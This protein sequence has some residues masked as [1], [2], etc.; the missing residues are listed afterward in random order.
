M[1]RTI[2]LI[3]AVMTVFLSHGA[4]FSYRFDS[5][6]LP[7]ALQLILS[8][9]P[10]L[11]LNFIY[12]EL[13]NYKTSAHVQADTAYDALRQTIG[14]NPVT[15]ANARGTYYLEALQHGRHIFTGRVTDAEGPLPGATLLL[16]TPKDSTVITYGITDDAGRFFIP[17]DKKKVIIKA[18]CMGYVTAY[19]ECD[20]FDAGDIVLVAKPIALNAVNIEARGTTLEA[21]KNIYIPSQRQ[22]QFSQTGIDLLR[23]MG[24]PS[25]VVE[26]GS[27][28]VTDVFGN[29]C[30]L[31]I[32]YLPASPEDMQTI[33]ITDVKRIEVLDSPA[34]PRFR[35]ATKAINIIVQKY[36]YGGYTK[37]RASETTL[38]GYKNSASIF[39]KFTYKKMTYDLYAGANNRVDHHSAM[40]MTS[41]YT[42]ADGVVTRHERTTKSKYIENSYPVT[43]RAVFDTKRLQVSNLVSYTHEAEPDKNR[44]GTISYNTRPNLNY[45]YSRTDNNRANSV[46]YDGSLFWVHP[47]DFAI[48]Y[49]HSASYTHRDNSSAFV[50]SAL[51]Y[52][53]DNK[54]A[55][56]KTVLRCD[57]SVLKAFGP[58]HRIKIGTG[59]LHLH[60]KVHYTN[61]TYFTDDMTTF[62]FSAAAQYTFTTR[63]VYLSAKLGY[64]HER[65]NVN[66]HIL[67]QSAPFGNVNIAY[68]INDKSRISA[69]AYLGVWSPGI[70]MRQ[71]AVVRNDEFMYLTGNSDL[72]NYN[73]LNTN[74]AYN[75]VPSNKFSM[76]AFT[77]YNEYFD[78]VATVYVPYDGGKALLRDFINDGNYVN[79]YIGV[80]GNFKLLS[81][82]LQLYA[83]IAQNLYNTTGIYEATYWA[84]LR[85]Q[86]SATY[87][88]KSFYGMVAWSNAQNVLTEN[89]N[90][91]IRR[92]SNYIVEAGWGNGT[93]VLSLRASNFFRNGWKSE[94]WE[95]K[96]PLYNEWQTHYSANA[97]ANINLSVSYTI[98]YG[99]KLKQN[100]EVGAQEA[101][102][103][104]ILKP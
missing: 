45:N 66:N 12:N 87:Y 65:N 82:S 64:G 58:K 23:H 75:W 5:T 38:N 32:N 92:R 30:E 81:N 46:K 22:K 31:F 16:L 20:G 40:D 94:T 17:C 93:W 1:V 104:A 97:H 33:K 78:R 79:Y 41:Q 70:G 98:G 85:V 89:S 50:N 10:D 71:D 26:P 73:N 53:I 39:S 80:S 63:K 95:R 47:R 52:P 100:N 62:N 68:S 69:F 99:K 9:H 35:G 56:D 18:L 24:I 49:F 21:D 14:L 76:A 15:I 19:R 83:N 90:I 25:L 44:L 72:G 103:S 86:L 55:E 57:L 34:D 74:L 8:D 29:K 88:W 101:S 28:V 91:T 67:N 77:G 60:D 51:D 48:N 3:A 59:V 54:A 84:P 37:V 7:Q 2:M 96:S 13:E 61:M 27:D 42:L 4:T 102:E 11:K 43:V 36:E 6:P